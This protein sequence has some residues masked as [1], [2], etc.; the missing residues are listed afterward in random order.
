MRFRVDQL[1]WTNQSQDFLL[2]YTKSSSWFCLLLRKLEFWSLE[3]YGLWAAAR[4]ATTADGIALVW[5]LAM[6]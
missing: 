4:G 2:L 1:L 6:L 3:V 5:G